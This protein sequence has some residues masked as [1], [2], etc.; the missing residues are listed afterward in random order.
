M[1]FLDGGDSDDE[2][3]GSSPE[4]EDEGD[5]DQLSDGS[6]NDDS[7]SDQDKGSNASDSERS[8]SSSPWDLE[9]ELQ[10]MKGA[11]MV[12]L[13]MFDNDEHGAD[14]VEAEACTKQSL[15]KLKIHIAPLSSKCKLSEPTEYKLNEAEAQSP[16]PVLKK[17]KKQLK[18]KPAKK[19]TKVTKPS[20]TRQKGKEN[21]LPLF[22]KEKHSHGHPHKTSVAPRDFVVLTYGE[23][24]IPPIM[25]LGRSVKGNKLKPQDPELVGPFHIM[26]SLSWLEFLDVLADTAEVA[27]GSISMGGEGLKWKFQGKSAKLPLKDEKG[28]LTLKA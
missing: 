15:P 19:S 11:S 28:F 26:P 2:I 21:A 23:I 14:K 3:E 7:E 1:P 9:P 17:L 12:C 27:K 6:A 22:T 18:E 24:I 20:T 10:E 25:I 8:S 5:L 4:N 13:V 16:C